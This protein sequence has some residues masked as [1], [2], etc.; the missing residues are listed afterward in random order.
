MYLN[1][2][3]IYF[4]NTKGTNS[5][6][7]MNVDGSNLVKIVDNGNVDVGQIIVDGNDLYYFNRY[8]SKSD[9]D[10]YK[11]S[12]NATAGTPTKLTTGMHP[13]GACICGGKIYFV[14]YYSAVLG[15]SHLYCISVDGGTPELI[16]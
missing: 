5:I 2:G 12:K 3:I 1:N 4:N 7:R 14:D 8:N 6:S 15:D 10:V 13:Y 9:Y 16:A 11:V